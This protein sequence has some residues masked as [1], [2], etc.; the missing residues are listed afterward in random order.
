MI[1]VNGSH[2]YLG[3]KPYPRVSYILGR[4]RGNSFAGVSAQVLAAAR[5]RG[6]AVHAAIELLNRGELDEASLHPIV[7]PYVDSYRA[8]AAILRPETDASERTMVSERHCFGGRCDWTGR[9]TA[10]KQAKTRWIID[11][12]SG[13]PQPTDPLQ[14]AAYWQL[15]TEQGEHKGTLLRASLYVHNDGRPA[16][17]VPHN[18]PSDLAVFLAY[19]TI[20]GWEEQ[21]YGNGNG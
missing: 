7:K 13:A 4:A 19:R 11:F 3:G 17:F 10:S 15:A 12:K 18:N 5:D 9:L 21:A 20:C 6:R 14:T 8:W 1:T 16:T 2:Y